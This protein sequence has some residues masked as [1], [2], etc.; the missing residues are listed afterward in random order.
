MLSHH[1]E[2]SPLKPITPLSEL[3]VVLPSSTVHQLCS[4]DEE[5]SLESSGIVLASGFTLSLL[6]SLPSHPHERLGFHAVL[7][8][9]LD[10]RI[11]SH[12]LLVKEVFGPSPGLTPPLADNLHNLMI[13]TA[14][15]AFIATDIKET[16]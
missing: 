11:L 5:K 6:C 2:H 10:I 9:S 7:E 14:R 12:W 13:V 8:L 3:R 15:L 16:V 1:T 4:V